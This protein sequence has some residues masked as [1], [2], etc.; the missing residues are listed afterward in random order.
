LCFL[1]PE[2]LE[3]QHFRSFDV[4]QSVL[5]AQAIK[6]TESTMRDSPYST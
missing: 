4:N 2:S 6:S 1:R 5:S 3:I